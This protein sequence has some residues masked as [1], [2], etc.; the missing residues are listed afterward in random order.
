LRR[1][2]ELTP[3]PDAVASALDALEASL[4][5]AG[6]SNELA[7][8]FRLLGE[9]AIT[10]VVKYADAAS[11]VVLLDVS[12]DAVTFELRDNGNPFDP[13]GAAAPDL[14]AGLE[15]R[16]LGGLGIHLMQ[17]L[18]DDVTYERDGDCNVL[19]LIKSR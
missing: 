9:E 1:T 12:D 17:T 10:N 16:P 11:I 8:E 4:I 7:L 13:L 2:F 3:H 5:D 14:D 15:E 18:A 6:A 19:R